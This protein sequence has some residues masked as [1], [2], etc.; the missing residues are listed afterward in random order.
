MIEMY[1]HICMRMFLGSFLAETQSNAFWS[2]PKHLSASD[3]PI[4]VASERCNRRF[5]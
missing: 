3:A 4:G 5:C 2:G 1:L